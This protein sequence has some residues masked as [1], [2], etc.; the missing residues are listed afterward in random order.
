MTAPAAFAEMIAQADRF[1]CGHIVELLRPAMQGELNVI[2]P[3][4]ETRMPPLHRMAQHGRPVVVLVGDDDYV[5]GGP[6]TWAC[7]AKLRQWAGFAMVH[8]TGAK[9]EHYAAAA[10]LT[11]VHRRLL[12]IETSSV[13]AQAWAGFLRE[14]SPV[15]PF[16]GL[17]PP[18]GAH[19]VM[20][21]PGDLH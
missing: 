2:L 21:S 17:L 7:A 8:G 11:R 18:D 1:G 9:P 3:T 6:A 19:P 14:R 12:L 13:D 15:L 16:M 5:P 20:P 10:M 4:P